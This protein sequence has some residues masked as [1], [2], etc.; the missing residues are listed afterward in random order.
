MTFST[1][2]ERSELEYVC[3][4]GD[5]GMDH[6]STALGEAPQ[7]VGKC[8]NCYRCEQFSLGEEGLLS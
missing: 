6:L 7:R 5:S 4:C 1:K 8:K 2:Q 3:K